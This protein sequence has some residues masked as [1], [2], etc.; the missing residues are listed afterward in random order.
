MPRYSVE[1]NNRYACFSSIV[2]GFITPFTVK[3]L[4]QYNPMDMRD[5]I[6]SIRL[7]NTHEE[8]IEQLTE[9]GISKEEAEK[10]VYDIE[11]EYYC[12]IP[13]N[14]GDFSCPNCSWEVVKG[15]VSC[16][17]ETCEIKFIWR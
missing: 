9:C 11:T 1:H 8:T 4:E 16:K 10:L 6:S 13:R 15:Q 12:P 14:D 3:N 17:N 7:H 5:A 2:D